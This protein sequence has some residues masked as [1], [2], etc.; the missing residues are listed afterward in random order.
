MPCQLA[1]NLIENNPSQERLNEMCK[2][3]VLRLKERIFCYC[4]NGAM[5]FDYVHFG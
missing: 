5:F 1:L 3:L 2:I 4:C